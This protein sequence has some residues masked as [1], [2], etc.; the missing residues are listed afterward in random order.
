MRPLL[1]VL[2]SLVLLSPEL[3]PQLRDLL[4]WTFRTPH[5]II[6]LT[7]R[8]IIVPDCVG[9]ICLDDVHPLEGQH[10]NYFHI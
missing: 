4:T 8:I 9:D 7:Y 5:P 10:R 3:N 6:L 2:F 1:K